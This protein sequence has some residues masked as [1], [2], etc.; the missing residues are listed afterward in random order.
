[1]EAQNFDNLNF[2]QSVPLAELHVHLGSCATP[3]VM[4][5]LAHAQGIRLP[6][7]DFWEFEKLI[8]LDKPTDYENY[9]KVYDL[10]ERIQSSPEA[11]FTMIQQVAGTSYR[12]NNVN[13]IEYRGNPI[14]RSR[15]G[16]IDLDHLIIFTLQGME[17]AMLK[18]PLRLGFI[19]CMDRRLS[20]TENE[21]IV[22]KAIKYKNRG[23]VGVDLAG[24][25]EINDQA[26]N[27][28]PQDLERVMAM[29]HEAGLGVTVHTGEATST[30]EMWAVVKYLKPQRIGHGIACVKDAKLMEYLR[31]NEI[32]L[33]TCPTSNLKTQ[34]VKDW[35]QL[36]E[37]YTTLKNYGVK[38]TIN[39]DGPVLQKTTLKREY[40][41]LEEK[42]ILSQEELLRANQIAH[43]ASFIK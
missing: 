35:S 20:V 3:E 27:F 38:F 32:V 5:E 8:S 24:P 36:K 40:C 2:L 25:V 33:E 6:T 4:W 12:V 26:R 31:E 37:I 9:L 18:Y 30:E 19:L 17:R 34:V 10:L 23:I 41:L 11:M 29:A 13:L 22:K 1:M 7:K 28:V 21:A 43:E 16:E 14:L 42:Q 39:T 15:H